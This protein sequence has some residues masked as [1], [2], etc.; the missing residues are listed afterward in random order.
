[1]QTFLDVEPN[2]LFTSVLIYSYLWGHLEPLLHSAQI[3]NEETLHLN[4]SDACRTICKRPGI[5]ESLQPGGGPSERLLWHATCYTLRTQ[6]LLDCQTNRV[7]CKSSIRQ[8]RHLLLNFIFQ[9][10]SNTITFRTDDYMNIFLLWCE[11]STFEVYRSTLD[12]T[13]CKNG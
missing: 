4:I 12:S 9:L 11:E 2:G 3:Q 10:N 8:L 6:L 5:F 1:M 7:S 13:S